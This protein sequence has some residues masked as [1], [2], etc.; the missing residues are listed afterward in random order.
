MKAVAHTI[1][2]LLAIATLAGCAA[3]QGP[4][5]A[6]EVP[7]GAAA[8]SQVDEKTEITGSRLPTRRTEKMVSQI[9]GKDYKDNKSA[10]AA[11]LE[12]H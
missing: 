7:L 2:S 9:G 4:L 1:A 8:T 10:L 12:S 11:P 3:R 5:N 6:D